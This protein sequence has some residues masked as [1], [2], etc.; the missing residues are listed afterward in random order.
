[1][2]G[3]C[4]ASKGQGAL[5]VSKGTAISLFLGGEGESFCRGGA[6]DDESN[7]TNRTICDTNED[8]KDKTNK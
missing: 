1:M 5:P 2:V 8:A 4:L 7:A 3:S 6:R